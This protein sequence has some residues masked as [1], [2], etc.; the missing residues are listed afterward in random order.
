M[1]SID[2]MESINKMRIALTFGDAGENHA[3]IQMVGKVEWDTKYYDTMRK[4]KY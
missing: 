1:E 2:K 4:K 3:G